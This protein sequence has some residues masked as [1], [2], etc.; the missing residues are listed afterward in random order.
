MSL[1]THGFPV[2][3]GLNW[4]LQQQYLRPAVGHYAM[5]Q[6]HTTYKGKVPIHSMKEYGGSGDIV[7]LII[8]LYT[9]WVWV[10]V[11]ILT[12]RPL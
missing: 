2:L 1:M 9:R 12:P 3:R 10:W 11:V 8:N 5:C 4:T 7:P 6:I